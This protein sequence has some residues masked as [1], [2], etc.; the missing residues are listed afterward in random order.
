MDL[1]PNVTATGAVTLR[2]DHDAFDYSISAGPGYSS[3]EFAKVLKEAAALGLEAVDPDECEADILDDGTI[4]VT[5]IPVEDE[6]Q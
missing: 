6:W 4:I 1:S 2:V 5:L 3:A